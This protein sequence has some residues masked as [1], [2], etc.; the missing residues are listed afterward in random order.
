VRDAVP[1]VES[2]LGAGGVDE[3]ADVQVRQSV[4]HGIRTDLGDTPVFPDGS[5]PERKRDPV[6]AAAAML[7]ADDITQPPPVSR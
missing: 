5:L 2:P 4:G 3:P 1:D 7:I 6:P